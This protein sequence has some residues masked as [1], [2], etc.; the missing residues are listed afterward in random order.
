MDE[1]LFAQAVSYEAYIHDNFA[2]YK[3]IEVSP[4]TNDGSMACIFDMIASRRVC[5]TSCVFLHHATTPLLFG[6]ELTKGG[7]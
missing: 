6:E 4:L 1:S 3:A 2:K 7:L 5:P